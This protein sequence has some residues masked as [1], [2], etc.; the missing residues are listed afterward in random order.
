MENNALIL[1]LSE[2]LLFKIEEGEF[3]IKICTYSI[4]GVEMSQFNRSILWT[5]FLIIFCFPILFLGSCASVRS[6]GVSKVTVPEI[7]DMTKAGASDQEIVNEIQQSKTVYKLDG[8]AYA[9]LRQI[10]VSDNVI[11][12]MQETY[13]NKMQ[14]SEDRDED[15]EIWN[16]DDAGY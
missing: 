16:I 1:L 6:N 4:K 14:N 13:T 15:W 2:F 7:I 10:G 3:R 5:S 12:Y 8:N 11:N 9:R